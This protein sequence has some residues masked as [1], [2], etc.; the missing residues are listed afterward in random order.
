LIILLLN[1]RHLLIVRL[2]LGCSDLN[3]TLYEL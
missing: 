1:R 2:G 3:P